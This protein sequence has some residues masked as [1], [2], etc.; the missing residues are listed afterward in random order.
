MWFSDATSLDSSI[1][2]TLAEDSPFRTYYDINLKPVA[3]M[4]DPSDPGAIPDKP[5]D[6]YEG[7]PWKCVAV[8]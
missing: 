5:I 4:F 3:K 2:A 1:K 8:H 7:H 6:M